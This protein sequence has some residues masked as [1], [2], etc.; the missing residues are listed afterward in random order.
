M[1]AV[2][3]AL[4]NTLAIKSPKFT[5][6]VFHTIPTLNVG[7]PLGIVHPDFKTTCQICI[8]PAYVIMLV[9]INDTLAGPVEELM[10]TKHVPQIINVTK[11]VQPCRYTDLLVDIDPLTI[12]D[13]FDPV[14]RTF[15]W[16]KIDCVAKKQARDAKHAQQLV[17]DEQ[18]GN[19]VMHGRS[20]RPK[21]VDLTRS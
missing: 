17:E 18:W 4:K 1:A 21:A 3:P 8:T 19:L 5:E 15:N 7:T 13:A 2:C 11:I 14:T 9:S 20:S 12:L 6:G 10:R 16:N